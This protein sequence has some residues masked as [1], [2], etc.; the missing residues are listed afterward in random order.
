MSADADKGWESGDGAA[1]AR[2]EGR[3]V[4]TSSDFV[5]SRK[6]CRR[7]LLVRLRAADTGAKAG[8]AG[9]GGD[10]AVE[11]FVR[12]MLGSEQRFPEANAD[13]A[14]AKPASGAARGDAYNSAL[15]IW[16][17]V[18]KR[19]GLRSLSPAAWFDVEMG[20]SKSRRTKTAPCSVQRALFTPSFNPGY[21]PSLR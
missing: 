5:R 3:G 9:A 14:V 13:A 15:R 17:P 1:A 10:V 19:G 12:D 16:L 7:R 6:L 18:L 20:A 11:A 8:A 2:T 21:T 4:L